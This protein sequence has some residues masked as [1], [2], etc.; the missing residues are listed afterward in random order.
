MIFLACNTYSTLKADERQALLLRVRDH[1]EPGGLFA[2]SL[3][4][5]ARLRRLPRRGA[6][7]IEEIFPHP[8]DGE[9]VQVSSAWERTNSEFRLIWHYDHLMPNGRVER[10]TV[11]TSHELEDPESYLA[12]LHQ[13]GLTISGLWGDYDRQSWQ[14]DSPYLIFA[15]QLVN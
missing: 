15:A 5:P 7:E 8:I 4:N 13:V 1:L 2:A 14:V 12:E 10:Q 11:K 3:P 6:P 9:P